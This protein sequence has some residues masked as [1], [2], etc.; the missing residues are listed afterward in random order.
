MNTILTRSKIDEVTQASMRLHVQRA[1]G[2]NRGLRE[3]EKGYATE[4]ETDR[5]Q[6]C[7]ICRESD[8]YLQMKTEKAKSVLFQWEQINQKL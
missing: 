4:R 8:V 7:S 2:K 6:G 5:A 1:P 3:M